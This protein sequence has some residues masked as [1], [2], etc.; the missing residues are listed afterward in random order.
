MKNT[1]TKKLLSTILVAISVAI[2]SMGC[3][4]SGEDSDTPKAKAESTIKCP[5]TDCKYTKAGNPES[6]SVVDT[7]PDCGTKLKQ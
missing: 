6:L 4:D 3:S 5:N 7:C 2:A 1:D